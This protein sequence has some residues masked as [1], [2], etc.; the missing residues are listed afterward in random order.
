MDRTL[1]VARRA[2]A[3]VALTSVAALAT[4]CGSSSSTAASTNA[5]PAPSDSTG[6]ATTPAASTPTAA[7]TTPAAPSGHAP[8]PTRS[9]QVKLGASQGTAGSIYTTIVFTNISNA[10]CTLYGYPGV[11]LQ[12]AKPRH[13]IGKPAKE[14]PAT[15]RQLV[16]LQPQAA[17]NALLRI[18]EAGNYP[19]G[20]CGPMTA[21]YLQVY[22]PNQTAPAYIRYTAQ[23]CSKPVRLMTVD[24]VKPGSGSS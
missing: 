12:T 10:T 15:P 24:V 11:S 21:H 8:C 9:L 4:A 13:Q 19:A 20:V 22:P 16:T 5:A 17:A 18:V 14:N 1:R 7:A 3:A 23:A 2:F 6:P